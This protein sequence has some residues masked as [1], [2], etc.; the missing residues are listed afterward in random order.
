VERSS[1]GEGA[2]YTTLEKGLGGTGENYLNRIARPHPKRWRDP[3]NGG[4][5]ANGTTYK[6]LRKSKTTK[7]IDEKISRKRK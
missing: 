7:K 2:K 3:L 4:E 5:M 6:K 1:K